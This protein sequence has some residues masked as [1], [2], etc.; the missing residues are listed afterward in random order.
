MGG[1]DISYRWLS[2]CEEYAQW[3]R[4]NDSNNAD[5][6]RHGGYALG[7]DSWRDFQG[8]HCVL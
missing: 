3:L 8:A 6:L 2:L 7:Q 4:V 1:Y 5:P